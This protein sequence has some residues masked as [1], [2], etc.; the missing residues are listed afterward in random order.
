MCENCRDQNQDPTSVVL[1]VSSEAQG[2]CAG[3]LSVTW[4]DLTEKDLEA[5]E[6][7]VYESQGYKN[8]ITRHKDAFKNTYE[9][10]KEEKQK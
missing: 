9:L 10:I 3:A 6:L 8:Y 4:E 2:H 1:H 7:A 5:I